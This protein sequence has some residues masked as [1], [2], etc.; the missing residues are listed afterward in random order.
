M[1]R[2]RDSRNN[3]QFG[4]T[5]P[6]TH[7]CDGEEDDGEDYSIDNLEDEL[8]DDEGNQED[9]AEARNHYEAMVRP[10]F[11]DISIILRR[12]DILISYHFSIIVEMKKH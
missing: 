11:D 9:V 7:V 12:K 10:L 1:A 3:T 2:N 4:D 6:N 8:E 5:L